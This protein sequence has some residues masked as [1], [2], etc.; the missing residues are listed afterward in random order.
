MSNKK[1]LGKHNVYRAVLSCTSCVQL[2]TVLFI[3][4]TKTLV[5]HET[6]ELFLHK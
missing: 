6:F 5:Y 2:A 3:K 1:N 4:Q